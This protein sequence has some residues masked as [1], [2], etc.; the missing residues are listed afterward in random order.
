MIIMK[1]NYNDNYNEKT[2]YN[3]FIIDKKWYLIDIL[4]IWLK[5]F[6]TGIISCTIVKDYLN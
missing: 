4:D 2:N 1:Y 3:R 6:C 5:F